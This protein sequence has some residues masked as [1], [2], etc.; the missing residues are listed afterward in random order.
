MSC[1]FTTVGEPE[2][3]SKLLVE[4][5]KSHEETFKISGALVGGK[6]VDEAYIKQL[7]AL[8]SKQEIRAK[9]VGTLKGPINGFVLNL[10]GLLQTLVVVLKA[11]SEK[12]ATKAS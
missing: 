4:Y 2:D 12:P 1:V 6:V 11:A 10:R 3:I 5:Q 8:P 7:A 9:A